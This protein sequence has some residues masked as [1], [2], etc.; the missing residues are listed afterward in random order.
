M[1][2]FLLFALYPKRGG[3]VRTPRFGVDSVVSCNTSL[4]LTE[5]TIYYG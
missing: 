2:L 5:S 1:Y 3:C 4:T